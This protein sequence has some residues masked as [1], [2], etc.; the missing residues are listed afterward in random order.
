M[1][2]KNDYL[3]VGS[4]RCIK[5][6]GRRVFCVILDDT[7]ALLI[8]SFNDDAI[9]SSFEIIKFRDYM[10]YHLAD[11]DLITLPELRS[12]RTAQFLAL[13]WKK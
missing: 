2:I 6:G 5:R 10:M 4:I 11:D 1:P 9:D 8:D 12:I 7:Q 3:K 13:R